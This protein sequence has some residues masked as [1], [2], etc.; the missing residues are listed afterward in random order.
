MNDP[1][2]ETSISSKILKEDK[3]ELEWMENK[4]KYN[5]KVTFFFHQSCEFLRNKM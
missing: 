5:R 3:M 2:F 1:N 4:N